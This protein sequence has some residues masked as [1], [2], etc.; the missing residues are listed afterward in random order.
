LPD[1]WQIDCSYDSY[2]EC[3]SHKWCEWKNDSCQQKSLNFNGNACYCVSPFTC[4]CSSF[5]LQYNHSSC[6]NGIIETEFGEECDGEP[7][8]SLTCKTLQCPLP[9]CGYQDTCYNEGECQSIGDKTYACHNGIWQIAC[10]NGFLDSNCGE[11]CDGEQGVPSNAFCLPDC[12]GWNCKAGYREHNDSCERNYCLGVPEERICYEDGSCD[13]GGS[14]STDPNAAVHAIANGKCKQRKI[15]DTSAHPPDWASWDNTPCKLI[16]CNP[17]YREHNGACEL[18]HCQGLSERICDDSGNCSDGESIPLDQVVANGKCRQI[19]I[20]DTRPHPPQWSSWGRCT[21]I[22]CDSGYR[23]YG[24]TC[25]L[26]HCEIGGTSYECG[27]E[28]EKDCKDRIPNSSEA[29]KVGTCNCFYHP[30]DWIWGRCELVSCNDGYRIYGNTCELDHCEG[31][32]TRSC[33]IAH[34]QGE[35]TRDCDTDLH[36]PE[37]LPWGACQIVSCDS[38]WADCNSDASD[39][40]ETDITTTEN[41]GG[42]GNKCETGELCCSGAC[43]EPACSE[44]SNCDDGKPSTV[45]VCNNPRECSAYCSHITCDGT[46]N[47]ICSDSRCDVSQ[48]PDCGEEGCCGDDICDAGECAAGCTDDCSVDDCCGNDTCDTGIG[49]NCS[50]CSDD[51]G[52]GDEQCCIGGT[53]YANDAVNPNNPCEKCKYSLNPNGWSPVEEGT[54]CGTC[55]ECNALGECV[56]S[57]NGTVC[58]ECDGCGEGDGRCYKGVCK[59]IHCGDCVKIFVSPEEERCLACT[60]D[61]LEDY[62]ENCEGKSYGGNATCVSCYKS[63]C[64]EINRNCC[65]TAYGNPGQYDV[66]IDPDCE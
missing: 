3:V 5:N 42:C 46:C 56:N 65:C 9:Q 60:E 20:C 4:L 44:D 15:C 30:P 13:D 36:P 21:V 28:A 53:C 50:N 33:S 57:L 64:Q 66:V 49:E 25:E 52:C 55:K 41:C 43:T 48:D 32:D 1:K 6:G 63:T 40:C 17:G 29:K 45:D 22:S 38:N 51:C 27:Q 59:T 16:S 37:W 61:A 7:N 23:I 18:D 54:S 34:G 11:N 58:S 8:C 62:C 24:N 14:I 2:A 31:S 47:G 19:R 12:S 35:Q 10:G 26:D 39:G